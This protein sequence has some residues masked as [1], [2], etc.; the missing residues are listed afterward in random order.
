MLNLRVRGYVRPGHA[1]LM[2]GRW[3]RGDRA[4]VFVRENRVV[5]LPAR[6]SGNREDYLD[7]LRIISNSTSRM[8][9][10]AMDTANPVKPPDSPSIGAM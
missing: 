2:D 8:I 4:Q 10:Q 5:S 3:Q 1:G 9:A 6:R 7:F